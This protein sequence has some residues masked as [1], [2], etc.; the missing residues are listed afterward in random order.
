MIDCYVAK[1]R[2]C[3]QE[4]LSHAKQIEVEISVYLV[5]YTEAT[6]IDIFFHQKLLMILIP[7]TTIHGIEDISWIHYMSLGMYIQYLSCRRLS[8]SII[9]LA[10]HQPS[11]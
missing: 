5:K 4:L 10:F 7:S 9:H 3:I 6:S 1:F 2:E 11:K 8:L